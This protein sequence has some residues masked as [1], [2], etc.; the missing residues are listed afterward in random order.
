MLSVSPADPEAIQAIERLAQTEARTKSDVST[1]SVEQLKIAEDNSSD[2]LRLN[3][4]EAETTESIPLKKI[5]DLPGAE[6]DLVSENDQLGFNDYVQAFADLIESSSTY[7]PLTVG[8]FGSWGIG[9]SFLL[10]HIGKEIKRRYEIRVKTKLSNYKIPDT[11][12]VE[13]NAWEYSSAQTI[14]PYLV[15]RIM[16]CLEPQVSWGFPGRFIIKLWYNLKRQIQSAKGNL[17]LIFAIIIG[18]IIFSFWK[19]GLDIALIWSASLAFGIGGIFKLIA[20]TLSK[21][22][23]QWV[24]TILKTNEY[25]KQIGYME[26]IRADLGLLAQRLKKD[27]DRILII[28][29]DLDRCE[30]QKAVEVLQAIKLLLDFDTFIICLGIDARIITRAVEKHYAEILGPAGVSGYEYLDKIVQIPFRIPVPNVDEVK[31]F[32]TQQ[33]GNPKPIADDDNLRPFE[34]SNEDFIQASIEAE[35][36][37]PINTSDIKKTNLDKS[38]PFTYDELQIFHEF[39]NFLKPNPRHLK[40]L[41]N[42][43]RLVRNLARHKNELLILNNPDITICWIVMSG[44][45]PYTTCGMIYLFKLISERKAEGK[46]I[47]FPEED[48]LQYLFEKVDSHIKKDQDYLINRQCLDYDIDQFRLLLQKQEG[49]LSWNDLDIICQYTI[50]FNPAISVDL[51]MNFPVEITDG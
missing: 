26:E 19:F 30:P 27:G 16:N 29:D 14:W 42:V 4:V 25:G 49:R 32:I 46:I 24:T 5:A 35:V 15:R 37:N 48:P 34:L 44:Q 22:L 21:P 20:D 38:V 6:N 41:M 11:Y 45:W 3:I 33:L 31:G 2:T 10:H 50:N 18:L 7:P 1:P 39:A 43:Y 23:S 40:R 8:I 9:K 51:K 13:F 28:I 36:S 47:H 17:I 12:I